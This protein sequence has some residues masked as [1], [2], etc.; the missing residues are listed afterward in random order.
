MICQGI[1]SFLKSPH[2]QDIEY[3]QISDQEWNVL[4][5]FAHMLSVRHYIIHIC[6]TDSQ[7]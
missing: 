2:C 7:W 5:D 3:L 1:D 4:L 6:H